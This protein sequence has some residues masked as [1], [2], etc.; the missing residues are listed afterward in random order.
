MVPV[1]PPRSIP[2]TAK[3]VKRATSIG[4]KEK[5][6]DLAPEKGKEE[7][8]YV[9]CTLT[10]WNGSNQVVILEFDLCNASVSTASDSRPIAFVK[11]AQETAFTEEWIL[12]AT[13]ISSESRALIPV[14][15]ICGIV[16]DCERPPLYQLFIIRTSLIEIAV[17]QP[18]GGFALRGRQ[19]EK[20][21]TISSK[22]N[23]DT[24]DFSNSLLGC[25]TRAI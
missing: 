18:I 11:R 17:E 24:S 14:V 9:R 21:G 13:G 20:Q 8:I 19:I 1:K 2:Q 15:T 23:Q 3:S 4:K 12:L 5:S 22:V 25:N 16:H 6:K 7:T 10:C